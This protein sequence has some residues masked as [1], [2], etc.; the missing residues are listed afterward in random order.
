MIR[1]VQGV[2]S[3][4]SKLAAALLGLTLLTQ[5]QAAEPLVLAQ[6]A[7]QTNASSATNAKGMYLGI[8]A[9][10]DQVNAAGGV[11]G[12]QLQV[13]NHNDDLNPAKMIEIMS[14][15]VVPDPKVVGLV[16]FVNTG[17][18]TTLAKED[19][20]GK[21]HLAMI[22]PLQ[23]DKQVIGAD[24]VYPFRAGYADEVKALVRH[25]R[26]M[27]FKKLGVVYY[28]IAFGPAM[29]KVAEE[30]AQAEGLAL[31]MVPL[32][33]AQ[34][35]V[36]QNA[37]AAAAALEKQKPDAVMMICAGRYAMEFAKAFRNTESRNAQLYGMSVILAENMVSS[38]GG[39]KAR[40]V[41]LAQA[42]PFP[43]SSV[44]PLVKE[45]QKLMK[46]MLPNEPLSFATLEGFVAGK[47]AVEGL[48][49]AGANPTRESL[50][51]ALNKL[52]DFDLGGVR[53]NYSA[54]KREGWRRVDLTFI[55]E[56]GSLLR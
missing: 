17:G 40:G 29:A 45:Y 12:R 54:A 5:A 39:A 21:A 6:I 30:A 31:T 19:A 22:A 23:G 52:G 16:G 48:R 42:V 20:F 1:A 55:R 27:G 47:L 50:V 9:Y 4:A 26:T 51:A 46:D 25:A 34:D 2:W 18:L 36:V 24:N 41:V 56:D 44:T 49:R 15:T 7:S 53:V 28:T 38:L 32:D 35:K 37:A 13:V 8:K 11:A 43:F 14:K 33:G 10:F 3:F